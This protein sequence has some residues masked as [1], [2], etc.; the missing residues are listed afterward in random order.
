MPVVIN[1]VELCDAD[2]QQ[3]L[4]RHEGAD[5]PLRSATLALVLRRVL[6]DEAAR[7]GVTGGNEDA[8]IDALLA[9]EVQVPA[10]STEECQR[11]YAQ[12]PARFTVGERVSVNHILFQVTARLDLDGLRKQ[13]EVALA[14]VLVHPERFVDHAKA[15]SNCPSGALGG[16]LGWLRRGE[17]V[18][19]FEQSVFGMAAGQI[20]PRLLETRFGLHIVQVVGREVGEL[21][22][23]DQVQGRIAEAMGAAS[24]DT[25]WRQYVSLLVGRADVQGIDLGGADSP[26]VQ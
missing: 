4:P 22:A 25:A 10:P 9:S 7:L 17:T 18:P 20:L 23:F 6:L 19:E 11:Y 13:A 1:G 24:R 15:L 5:N 3:E 21:L 26:L 2:M 8:V 16:S 14:D 12:N